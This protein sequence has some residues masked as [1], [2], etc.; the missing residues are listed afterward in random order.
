MLILDIST[1]L[2]FLEV[3]PSF[4]QVLTAHNIFF[5]FVLLI[6]S[7]Q[8]SNDKTVKIWDLTGGSLN[9]DTEI[10]KPCTVLSHFGCGDLKVLYLKVL[11][12]NSIYFYI[13]TCFKGIS[14]VHEDCIMMKSDMVE[15]EVMLLKI[16]ENLHTGS[17]NSL[18]FSSNG[19]LATA[20]GS[21]DSYTY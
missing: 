6:F 2:H 17:I 1:A 11:Y 14:S 15:N 3:L 10:I 16:L 5:Q 7:L 8:G 13:R 9:I 21:E 18:E 20:S 19:Y 4:V 12:S